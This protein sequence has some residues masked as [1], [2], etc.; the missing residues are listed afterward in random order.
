M[1]TPAD[2]SNALALARDNGET[3]AIISVLPNTSSEAASMGP[4]NLRLLVDSKGERVAGGL[5]SSEIEKKAAHH[6]REVIRN[7]R[8]DITALEIDGHRVL[9]EIARPPEHVIICG[10]GHVGRAV[11]KAAR[12]LDFSVTVID[13]RADFV[14]RERFPDERV[15][16]MASDFVQALREL[17]F[18]RATHVVI[19]TRGHK[20]DEICLREVIERPARYIGMIGSRRRTTTIREHLRKEGVSV[21]LLKRVH[22]PVGLDIG[23]QTPEEIALAIMSEVIMVRRGGTGLSKGARMLYK[24]EP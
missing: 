18:N 11:A 21:E 10:G 6:A 7:D 23:A 17:Q 3:I 16:L 13:D 12:F 4:D 24:A 15:Q 22:A 9:I 1:L 8:V 20:H 19:V 5:G 14:S 2:I